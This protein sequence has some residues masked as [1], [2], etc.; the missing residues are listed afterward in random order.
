MGIGV[1]DISIKI[2]VES[3][4]TASMLHADILHHLGLIISPTKVTIIMTSSPLLSST[5]GHCF[6]DLTVVGNFYPNFKVVV[7]PHL[8]SDV[9]LGQNIMELHKSVQFICMAPDLN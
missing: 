5:G 9:I 4:S 2:P 7:L 1:N 8:C 3:G 6:V